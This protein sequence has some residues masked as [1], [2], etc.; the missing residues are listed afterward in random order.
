MLRSRVRAPPIRLRFYSSLCLSGFTAQWLSWFPFF[1]SKVQFFFA[2]SACPVSPCRWERGVRF[3]F[4]SANISWVGM[5]LHFLPARM[6]GLTWLIKLTACHLYCFSTVA[7]NSSIHQQPIRHTTRQI[8]KFNKNRV[9][10]LQILRFYT[11]A[12]KQLN[13]CTTLTSHP[14]RFLSNVFTH[15]EH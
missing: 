6:T 1:Y 11:R 15:Y 2:R 12:L 13:I 5:Q 14:S 4:Q 7:I 3:F 8:A 9:T 10:K